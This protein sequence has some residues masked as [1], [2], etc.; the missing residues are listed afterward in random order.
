MSTLSICNYQLVKVLI[1]NLYSQVLMDKA[2]PGSFLVRESQSQP[3]H[4]VL[5]VRTD[6]TV[7][8]VKI[9][10]QVNLYGDKISNI[11]AAYLNSITFWYSLLLGR[12]IRRRRWRQIRLSLRSRR[13]L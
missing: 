13:T 3:G 1:A 4:F 10:A 12:K 5:S 8:H 2:K 7:T 11:S 9:R 6:D